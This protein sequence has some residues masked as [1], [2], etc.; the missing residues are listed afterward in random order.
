MCLKYLWQCARAY[1]QLGT[2]VPLPPFVRISLA[3]PEITW[4]IHTA[5]DINARVTGRCF[6]ALVVN[7]LVDDFKSRS[8]LSSGVYDSELACI[9]SILGTMPGEILRWP[10]SSAVIKLLNVVSLMSGE[11]E[12]LLTSE[13]TP[14]G[15]MSVGPTPVWQPPVAPMVSSTMAPTPVDMLSIVQQTIDI[16][17]PELVLGGAFA[18]GDLPMRQVSLLREIC[19]KIANAQPDNRFRIQ[20]MGILDKLQ[21]ISKK[22]PTVEYK[23]RRCAS[24]I[25]GPQFVRGRVNS[26]TRPEYEV[27]R[28]SKSI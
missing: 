7:K 24:S 22:L 5:R 13:P 19:S 1:N 21:Q 20:T 10:H 28:R 4:R 11:I 17:S 27:R 23:M 3:N 2:S 25:F 15:S 14:A 8:S 18:C 9:S 16:I 12:T 26:T 6:G